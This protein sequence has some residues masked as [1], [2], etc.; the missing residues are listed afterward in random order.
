MKKKEEILRFVCKL[1]PT[2]LAIGNKLKI[3][4]I[5]ICN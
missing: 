4:I 2:Q 5:I 3:I 1:Q